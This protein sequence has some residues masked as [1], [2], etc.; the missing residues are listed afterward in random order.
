MPEITEVI[1][2]AQYLETIIGESILSFESNGKYDKLNMKMPQMIISIKT[3]GKFMWFELD[4]YY[5]FFTFGLT[6][7]L[8]LIPLDYIKIKFSLT[9]NTLYLSD[10]LNYGS[11]S[12]VEK[13]PKLLEKKL[14][15]LGDDFLQEPLS[16]Q[17]FVNLKNKIANKYPD[18]L[19]A[20]VLM[21]QTNKGLGSGIGNYL[22]CEIL[23]L[24]KISPHTQIKNISDSLAIILY[25]SIKYVIKQYY[26]YNT[27]DYVTHFGNYIQQ[28]PDMINNGLI[29]N[30]CPDVQID[31]PPTLFVYKQKV[32]PYGNLINT[33]KIG[34]RTVY[35]S[36]VQI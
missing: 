32:D 28:R 21:D 16:V 18:K 11:V 5:I 25:Q 36:S 7:K 27:T 15:Q 17:E 6:G 9:K 23:F 2:T 24:S 10:K 19:I 14:S 3:K 13:E 33:S 4:D 35:W 1:I 22:L 30:Y 34:D 20:T 29:P 12:I 31:G 8:S 26:V